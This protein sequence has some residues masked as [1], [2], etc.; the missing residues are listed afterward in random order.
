MLNVDSGL[1]DIPV[2]SHDAFDSVC[3]KGLCL[4]MSV[5]PRSRSRALTFFD[6]LS[7]LSS[8]L[9]VEDGC[10]WS[11]IFTSYLHIF[12]IVRGENHVF[13]LPLSCYLCDFDILS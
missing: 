5:F 8:D 10:G 6:R 3:S 4:L 7:F 11:L 2:V 13:V 1:N 12:H 9:L